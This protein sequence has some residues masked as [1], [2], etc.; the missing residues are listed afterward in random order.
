MAGV[1]AAQSGDLV[2]AES[3]FLE[4]AELAPTSPQ[5]WQNLAIVYERMGRGQ[6]ADEARRRAQD[7]TA[8]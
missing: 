5:P 1:I 7:L 4:A 8:K 2:R 3:L 6:D